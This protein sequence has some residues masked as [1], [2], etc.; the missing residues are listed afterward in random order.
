MTSLAFVARS[1]IRNVVLSSLMLGLAAC[2]ADGVSS[3]SGTSATGST[4]TAGLGL[5]RPSLQ[6]PGSGLI[7]RS[8][9]PPAGAGGNPP[10][11]VVSGS[12]T[13]QPPVKP[14]SQTTNTG[15]GSTGSGS[16]SGGGTNTVT[17]STTLDWTPPTQNSDGTVLTN[18][19]GY[20]VYYGTAP[21]HLTESVKIT[22]PGLSAYTISNL[23]SGTWY[24][25]VSAYSAEGTESARSATVSTRI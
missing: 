25:S 22:N 20:T 11:A 23:T 3:S 18:L 17:G 21:D 10:T 19:A 1:Q 6:D 5:D 7:D 16:T 4:V 12:K 14:P 24:F 13:T 8:V 9:T 15:S 2:G